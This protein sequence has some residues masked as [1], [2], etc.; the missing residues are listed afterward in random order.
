[1]S[2]IFFWRDIWIVIFSILVVLVATLFP[3]NFYFHEINSF[4]EI[5]GNFNN[6][7][8]F[9]DQVNNVFLFMPLGFGIASL[10]Q[11]FRV[12]FIVQLLV[13]LLAGA[14][15]STFVEVLQI[16]LPSRMPTPADI[17]N[18][19]IG[20]FLGF[21][22]Y[23]SGFSTKLSYNLLKLENQYQHSQT[24]ITGLFIGYI[25][26][27]FI[28]SIFWQGTANLSNWILEYPLVIGNEPTGDRPWDGYVSQIQIADRAI[29]QQEVSRSFADKNYLLKL[30]N[31]ILGSYSLD[32]ENTVE[33]KY[34]DTTGQLPP[35]LWNTKPLENTLDKNLVVSKN[36]W[37]KTLAPVKSINERINKTS[38]FTII[39]TLGTAKIDQTGPAR[40]ISISRN[41]TH[42]N[43]SLGQENNSL[44]IRLRTPITGE[45][46]ADVKLTIPS[47]FTDNK[48]HR[49]IITYS[50]AT[51]QVYID[52]LQNA[53]SFNLLNLMPIQQKIFYSA[54]TFI[55]LGL[56]L[57]IVTSVA[58]RRRTF[59][60]LLL[61][62][63]VIL[64][65]LIL[66]SVL[67]SEGGKSISWKNLLL[68]ILTTGG[69]MLLFKLRAKILQK[70]L[71]VR[72]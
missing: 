64:P 22:I 55:P 21:I 41:P 13:V 65:A 36:N 61:T 3:F 26:L 33:D 7:S 2:K 50:Q 40:I 56:C 46:G 5:I 19:T 9:Q 53:Y 28:I 47:V 14:S 20:G 37:L 12:K 38:E 17:V 32:S 8:S 52:K 49:F 31:T 63:G 4:S 16:F 30:E 34:Q 51:L 48:Q 10:F 59:Y 29:S 11:K 27:A 60:R 44:D 18:N 24:K 15:L 23:Y 1:M 43:F 39:T 66:E 54:F 58:K 35:L 42:R 68:S 69:T 72:S 45:N 25:L 62:S 70:E 57:A 71:G 67:V 6:L